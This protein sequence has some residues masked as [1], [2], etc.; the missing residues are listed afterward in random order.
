METVRQRATTTETRDPWIPGGE[1]APGRIA[2]A[3]IRFRGDIAAI[4]R[5]D[6][7]ELLPAG[8]ILECIEAAASFK[9]AKPAI[10]HLLSADIDVAPRVITYRELVARIRAAASL[11]EEVSRGRAAGSR[12]HPAYAAG[13]AYRRLG[14]VVGGRRLPD[15]SISGK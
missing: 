7:D 13:G 5:F 15:Q 10:K 2:R 4:E 3:D 12:H 14:R 11:F 6:F 9:P 8:A 1:P